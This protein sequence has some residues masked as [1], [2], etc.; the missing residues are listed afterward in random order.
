MME[1]EPFVYEK[2]LNAIIAMIR[3]EGFVPGSKLPGV[4]SLAQKFGCNLHT[5]R[6]AIMFLGENGV[7]ES[8]GRLGNFVRCDTSHL[9]GRTQSRLQVVSLRRI[10]VLLF[11]A[12]SEFSTSLLI[13][14]Q[15]EAGRLELQLE[16]HVAADWEGAMQAVRAM[17]R[18]NCRAMIFVAER[19]RFL[20]DA[21]RAFL[22]SVPLPLVLGRL[23]TG[24]EE[25]CYEPRELYSWF[26]RD[27]VYFQFRYFRALGFGH[28]AYFG[29]RDEEGKGE[30]HFRCYCE[31]A[32]EF[33]RAPD[34]VFAGPSPAEVDAALAGWDCRRGDLAVICYDDIEA[35]RLVIAARKSGWKLPE[36]MAVMGVN[37]FAFSQYVDPPLSTV[38][39]P[40]RYMAGRMLKR[41][42]DFL[43]EREKFSE[44]ALPQ[45]EVLI[46]DSC[47]GR[48]RRSE[49]ELRRLLP[50]LGAVPA[51]DM[52]ER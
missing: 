2:V 44:A 29:R 16:H 33:R 41:A 18:S 35:M 28:I 36:E 17:K 10:G 14:L 12:V 42:L 48:L 6:K 13:E 32:E 38:L 8:Q 31:C 49:S 21:A 24:Y 1:S 37:N 25:L 5:V 11:P 46:R 22:E 34:G 15:R 52:P 51:P 39:F 45:L 50:Q 3:D 43:E 7:V 47:C 40:Y 27:T 23:V 9:I 30:T 20:T 26:D 19:E 4:R